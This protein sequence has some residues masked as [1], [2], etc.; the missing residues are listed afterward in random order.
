MRTNTRNS[1]FPRA[2]LILVTGCY[3]CRLL[4]TLENCLDSDQNQQNISPDPNPNLFDT[5]SVH[6]LKDFF[7]KSQQMTT[8]A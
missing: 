6:F 1:A 5:D 8:K 4:I 7:L 3:V 2:L